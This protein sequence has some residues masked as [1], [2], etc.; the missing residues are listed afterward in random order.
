MFGPKKS[1]D[2]QARPLSKVDYSNPNDDILDG[3]YD[4]QNHQPSPHS[5][6]FQTEKLASSN[7]PRTK[8]WVKFGLPAVLLAIIL[9][10][11]LGA[12]LGSRHNSASGNKDD[13]SAAR[14][15]A[16]GGA[17]TSAGKDTNHVL[18]SG[19]NAY[20]VPQYPSSASQL[21]NTLPTFSS[22]ANLAWG[23]DPN[24]PDKSGSTVRQDHPRLFA[25]TYKWDRLPALIQ[26]DPYLSSWNT[27][28]F[29]NATVFYNMEPTNYSID[30]GYSGSGVLD[31]AR[32][33]QLR[34][35]YWAYAYRLTKDTKWV[36]RAWRELQTAAG[37]TTQPFGRAGNNWNT[38]HW[39]DVAEFTIAFAIAYDW[40]YEAWTAEQRNAIMWSIINLGLQKGIES[41]ATN[42]WFLTTNGNWNCITN[43]G[44]VVGS[45]AIMNEDPTGTA[46]KLLPLALQSA[47]TNC[48][49]AVS[50]DGTWSE[51]S[52]YW[53]FGS[54]GHAHMTSALQTATGSTHQ[55]LTA[56][57]SFNLT[58]LYHMYVYGNTYKANTGDCGPNKYVA[59]ANPLL[60]YGDQYQ[61]PRYILYQR[62]R[63]DAA[64]PLSMFWYN[65]QASGGWF[66]DLPLD[67]NFA[68]PSDAWVSMRSSWTNTDG[69][70]A[71]VKS[72]GLTGHQTHDFL[73]AGTLTL[74]ALGERWI[75]HLCQNDYLGAGY[76]SS[77][78]VNSQR[79]LYYRCRTEGQNTLLIGGLNQN[80][81]SINPVLNYDSTGD[82]QSNINFNV[83]DGQSTAFWSTDLTQAY[84]GTK[85]KRGLRFINGRTQILV[86][87]EIVGATVT[88]QWRV[89]TNSTITVSGDGTS[90]NMK[91]NGKTMIAKILSPSGTKFT[92]S[93]PVR[94]PT[95]P[96]VPSGSPDLPNPGVKV[97]TINIPAGSNTVS[98]LFS[99]QWGNGLKSKDDV[100]V[101]A[102]DSWSLT[103]HN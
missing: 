39:L 68:D 55:L 91:L 35:K 53:Y 59:T 84:N 42:A 57:P 45:L 10:V 82:R 60:Y 49:N 28:I 7:K 81:T 94:L 44:M 80:P 41:H 27:T 15:I 11:V 83:Q 22:S 71:S 17:G 21:F 66:I 19:Y 54:Q 65:P 90:A 1:Q 67:N 16:A 3:D 96:P 50:T 43:G 92:V 88:S 13:S 70:F 24:A 73:D 29:S 98:V 75:G 26:V 32:E 69:V 51:T 14:S 102:L 37:N 76:F 38:D 61:I 63:A 93:D 64:D 31:V 36:D 95:S 99:P 72:G 6:K 89:H 46:S 62:D 48:V 12:V 58:G 79:W 74:D 52:D 8:P 85:V 56:N 33:V 30:G 25:P 5:T 23:N 101:L 2:S 97:L 9:A 100:K 47:S 18:F 40:M 4:Q 103:S 20:G 87:D 78:G 34:L 77:E 86:Q